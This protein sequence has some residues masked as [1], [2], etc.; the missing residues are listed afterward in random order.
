M[1]AK[2]ILQ[3]QEIGKIGLLH[4]SSG[5]SMQMKH[6][7]QLAGMAIQPLPNWLDPKR[8]IN[9]MRKPG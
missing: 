9:W 7:P 2:P 8:H 4:Q 3:P 1:V 5:E 6:N